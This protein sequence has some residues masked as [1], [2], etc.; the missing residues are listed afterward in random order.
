[1]ASPEKGVAYEFYMSLAS[2]ADPTVFQVDPTI[3]A[4]DFTISK[5]GGTFTNLST[6]PSVEPIS[7]V[8]VK[9]SLSATEMDADSIVIFAQDQAD[10][11]WFEQVVLV[12]TVSGSDEDIQ[13]IL[14][15]LEGDHT[16]SSAELLIKKKGTETILVKKNITGSLLAAAVTVKTEEP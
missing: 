16:E 15:I 12:E 10:D 4:G 6:L 5:D 7:S 3:V 13:T 9:V 11:E 2:Q 8:S 14:D 1:M